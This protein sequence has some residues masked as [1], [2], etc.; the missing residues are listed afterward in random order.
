M[1]ATDCMC[2]SVKMSEGDHIR[3]RSIKRKIFL[4]K[5]S[6]LML[7][8]TD[9]QRPFGIIE[10]VRRMAFS[11]IGWTWCCLIAKIVRIHHH[12]IVV[13]VLNGF[14]ALMALLIWGSSTTLVGRWVV[15]VGL[16]RWLVGLV[17]GRL[18]G[19][20]VHL[21]IG[22]TSENRPVEILAH[23][24][25]LLGAHI[26]LEEEGTWEVPLCGRVGEL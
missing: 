8:S 10:V 5:G 1:M 12:V 4:E 7:S 24:L 15:I 2:P 6:S 19:F 23:F 22:R 14:I 26:A 13:D 25:V 18:N 9:F 11:Q 3:A 20:H 16:R 17:T 21:V